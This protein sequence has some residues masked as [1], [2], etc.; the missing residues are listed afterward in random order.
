[1]ALLGGTNS[2]FRA[3]VLFFF[4]FLIAHAE[5]RSYDGVGNNVANPKAGSAFT[6]F[7]QNHT[8]A[9]TATY[10]D[11]SNVTYT[12]PS[13]PATVPGVWLAGRCVSDIA[14]SYNTPANNL[15]LRRRFVSTTF[16]TH[17]ITHF[18]HY[19]SFDLTASE[20]PKSAPI[21]VPFPANDALYQSPGTVPLNSSIPLPFSP[22]LE[23]ISDISS[24]GHNKATRGGVNIITGFL[25]QSALY[26][27]S[28]AEVQR[29]RE[30]TGCRMKT[31]LDDLGH[32]YP[33]RKT[34]KPEE[35]DLG[36]WSARSGDI[37]STLFSTMFLREH[38]LYCANLKKD[39]GTMSDDDLFEK[40]R[41]YIIGLLQHIT[42]TEY[43]ATVLGTTPP[44][45]S[46]TMG[47][48]EY[49]I[50]DAQN[51]LVDKL[52]FKDTRT[53]LI[54][55]DFGYENIARVLARQAQEEVDIYYSDESR[56]YFGPDSSPV[57][58]AQLD[59][60][61]G[62]D[63]LL[64]KYN[65]A[66]VIYNLPPAKTF[67][68]ISSN[69]TIQ[70]R[71]QQLYATVD[72][73]EMT[74]GALAEDHDLR[75]SSSMGPLFR[76]GM[77]A[78]FV[79]IRDSDRFWYQNE[80]VLDKEAYDKVMDTNLRTLL[81][82]HFKDNSTLPAS[83]W[84]FASEGQ[85]VTA[86]GS[87]IEFTSNYKVSWTLTPQN[88]NFE[89]SFLGP[90]G[91]FGLG[92]SPNPNMNGAQFFVA[93]HASEDSEDIVLDKY[94]S[95][96]NAVVPSF[97][98]HYL[99]DSMS[100]AE[101]NTPLVIKFSR[102]LS[103]QDGVKISDGN[104][105]VLF[106]FSD[107]KRI[108]YHQ[109]GDSHGYYQVN[110]F[111]NSNSGNLSNSPR[112]THKWHGIGMFICWAVIF[113]ASI[114][115][116]RYQKHKIGNAI[117]L[118][119]H[120]Q[121]LTG[122]SITSLAA[123]A[124]ATASP[125]MYMPHKIMGLTILAAVIGQL[126]LGIAAIYTLD[127]LESANQGFAMII[128]WMHRILGTGV[129]L[130]AWVNIYFGLIA[131]K[132]PFGVIIGYIA[133]IAALVVGVCIY[134]F[135]WHREGRT[136]RGERHI[137]VKD[138]LVDQGEKKGKGD[139]FD[140][141]QPLL[142]MSKITWDTINN[143]V[144]SGAKLVVVDD[145]VFD[146]REWI[147][148]HPGGQKVLE[149]VIGTD[150]TEDFYGHSGFS[151]LANSLGAG[152]KGSLSRANTTRSRRFGSALHMNEL[153]SS[154][155][156]SATSLPQILPPH[157]L[158]GQLKHT[159]MATNLP[160]SLHMFREYRRDPRRLSVHD[161]RKSFYSDA[162][163]QSQAIDELPED[164]ELG[165]LNGD[166]NGGPSAVFESTPSEHEKKSLLDRLFH[167]FEELSHLV[168]RYNIRLGGGNVNFYAGD[169][170][171]DA[172]Q[173][174]R[175]LATHTHTARAIQ[176]LARYC[177]GM[178][179]NDNSSVGALRRK[180]SL[181][182]DPAKKIFKR[183]ILS[184]KTT[185][186]SQTTSRPVR[187]FT[188]R[189]C[190]GLDKKPKR[191]KRNNPKK[192]F[193][194]GEYIEIQCTVDGQVLTRSYTPIEGNM[195]EE[196]AIYV[197]IYSD[198]MVSRFLDNQ[199]PGYEIRIRGPFDLS[200]KY[201]MDDLPAAS[202]NAVARSVPRM[203]Y[204]PQREDG[205]WNVLLMIVGGTG[206][207]PALQMIHHHIR[208]QDL[209]SQDPK[210]QSDMFVL[211]LNRS[212]RDIIAGPYMDRLVEL[213]G[214]RLRVDY[215]VNEANE[216]TP[217]V[218]KGHLTPQLLKQWF[219]SVFHRR[220]G[221]VQDPSK[222][223]LLGSEIA[224]IGQQQQQLLQVPGAAATAAAVA[225]EGEISDLRM[226]MIM[227]SFIRPG[228]RVMLSGT[229]GMMDVALD[230]LEQSQY[231]PERCIVLH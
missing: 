133:Y 188:F 55:E 109:G 141:V 213:S 66:R 171:D 220:N 48:D 216:R 145:Y 175:A 230:F 97:Q 169:G 79:N 103:V 123:A 93:Q 142:S 180:T 124:I 118:H 206:L 140:D 12:C 41:A 84:K 67:A 208:N 177:I 14:M 202:I 75:P 135:R 31:R 207:T 51:Q 80:G 129:L 227:N 179:D 56:N 78:Q 22:T 128:K 150:I 152:E 20:K 198:G 104:L 228:V 53:R 165:V 38:N 39:Y 57:D 113:P 101:A 155:T 32:E 212:Y 89:L 209:D 99:A 86:G 34:N 137:L 87:S 114:F 132:A 21:N 162:M 226:Q 219:V 94:T 164:N 62:R 121:L 143:R 71:L 158:V 186:T 98:G 92:L 49:Q 231:P 54:L 204:N 170:E 17:M 59:V 28:L 144:N 115:I 27:S 211:C 61:R 119:R 47:G 136:F 37:F 127:R 96:G 172:A 149:R 199:Y 7:L 77:M 90:V 134:H 65:E 72:D 176:R 184:S 173:A 195:D 44:V 221:A 163:R 70:L 229:T 10:P 69:P 88:I 200:E 201:G 107:A 147:P 185:L 225:E 9:K 191:T 116:V 19:V 73:V 138:Y 15:T 81:L 3:L 222:M 29:L 117:S 8:I 4:C 16:R 24:P 36:F 218:F 95:N 43:L 125:S 58:L 25:D 156:A 148:S 182:P 161:N 112:T 139:E 76:A 106:A 82:K 42:Y 157:K 154:S 11:L 168:D 33:P 166:G 223:E 205:R 217:G 50:L 120:I 91:W 153:S 111:T 46:P 6:P 151:S 13:G 178:I 197:K 1:M 100:K 74:V 196:F 189:P 2:F 214:N 122:F 131:Y 40:T 210:D 159:R 181:K 52:T 102:P 183:Y 5:Y 146:I 174:S 190:T 160:E 105:Y 18:A 110:F 194:P 193:A 35:Y 85:E 167:W 45:K 192:M 64:P 203:L 224:S 215:G 23:T 83:I 26:G 108:G 126:G 187:R 30:P 68:D 63:H 130:L 60:L